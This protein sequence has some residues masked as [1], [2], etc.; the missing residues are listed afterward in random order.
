MTYRVGI[1]DI[2]DWANIIDTLHL[3]TKKDSA[4]FTCFFNGIKL[5]ILSIP[6]ENNRFKWKI[7]EK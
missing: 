6:T 1:T 2:Y 4:F 7:S 3:H 5:F